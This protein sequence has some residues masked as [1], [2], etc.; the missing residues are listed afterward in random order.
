MIAELTN[1]VWQSTM[2]AIV[3]GL[4]TLAFRRNRAQVRYWLWLGAS[5]KF[6][7]PFSLL[8]SFGNR[9]DWIP[10]SHSVVA[11]PA[12]TLAVVQMSRPF[13]ATSAL[14]S[15]TP[16][17]RD[18]TAMAIFGLWACGFIAI[19]LL[20]FQGWRRIRRAVRSSTPI[21]VLGTIQVR[22]S[23]GLLE[24]GVVGLFRPI[25]LVPIGIGERLQPPQLRAV[26]AHEVCH[27]QRQDNLTSAIHMIVEAIFWFH[28]LVWWI[29]A[30]LMEERER[31]CDEA[32]LGLGNEP[33]E[34]AQGILNICKSYLESP[35]SC[36]SG[37]TGSNLKR[38]IQAI[39]TGRVPRDLTFA[40]KLALAVAGIAALVVPIAV[41]IISPPR[42]RAQSQSATPKF[43]IQSTTANASAKP[44]T[45]Q[46]LELK[47]GRRSVPGFADRAQNTLYPGYYRIG[48]AS[49]R[50]LI[51]VAYGLRDF[52]VGGGP[53]WIDSHNYE[54]TAKATG[55]PSLEEWIVVLGPSFQALLQDRFKLK[56]HYETRRLPVYVL[57]VAQRGDKLRP[58][59][60]KNCGAFN[61]TTYPNRKVA[62][63]CGA[64]AA[65]NARLNMQLDAVG[66]KMTTSR[67]GG[68][69]LAQFLS[70]R[71]NRPVIDQTGLDGLYDFQLEWNVAATRK[72]LGQS[73]TDV[74]DPSI[75]TA[76]QDQLGLKLKAE[77]GPVKVLTVDYAETPALG[78]TR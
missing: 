51:Q 9:L 55:K 71:L 69:G 34:Y 18:W 32:V 77:K 27:V 22:S 44:V 28:P 50:D 58:S 72:A 31:A 75:F 64:V 39:L 57:T 37:A 36:V 12:I 40:K 54:V 8:M 41:G 6:L 25:L 35:L 17:G 10:A 73:V 15:Y 26:L 11:T 14:A 43:E 2:F 30:R 63:E 62:N 38:R 7:L 53:D 16:V 56:F 13:P 61:F 49:L 42:I 4:I 23:P 59:K 60:E 33:H 46:S 70:S 24:P 1:H 78:E 74:N 21:D 66:M 68:P 5:L 76:L 3:V 20:R 67:R 19:T 65:V 48:D 47:A 52:Q 45:L 29:G